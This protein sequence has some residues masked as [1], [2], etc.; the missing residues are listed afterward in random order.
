LLFLLFNV[1]LPLEAHLQPEDGLAAFKPLF[2]QLLA[3]QLSQF[4]AFDECMG[5]N[6]ITS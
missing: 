2:P 6:I 1:E 4:S 3:T 5:T